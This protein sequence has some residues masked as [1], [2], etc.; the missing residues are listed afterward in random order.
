MLWSVIRDLRDQSQQTAGPPL[1]VNS[2][3]LVMSTNVDT[4]LFNQWSFRVL[5]LPA[6]RLEEYETTEPIETL[7]SHLYGICLLFA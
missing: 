2:K 1:I 3:I 5:N 7:V 4:R 6:S